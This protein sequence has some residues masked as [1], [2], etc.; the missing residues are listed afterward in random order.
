MVEK[1]YQA[2]AKHLSE[3]FDEGGVSPVTKLSPELTVSQA[4]QIQ[5][6]TIANELS[7]GNQITG[8]KIGLTSVAMQQSLGVDE[9]DYG[10][11]LASMEIVNGGKVSP[12]KVLQPKVE[13]ELA[14]VLK[15]ELRGP[16]V[17][18]LDVVMATDYVVPALEIV[19]SRIKNWEITLAD[20]VADN[21]SSGLY[22]LGEERFNLADCDLKNIG[23]ALYKNGELLN[24]GAG[25]ACLGNPL[26]GV[27]WLANK[28][29]EFEIPLKK[30]E[31]ILSGALSE[32]MP[33]KPG[34]VFT[35][36]F[37]RMGELTVRF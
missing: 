26:N 10:H 28:L 31:V 27:V 23:M 32:A 3:A 36:K 24:T 6:E 14:F 11:L 18:T 20:T 2:L 30:G 12:D 16:H 22:V 4:Y 7:K 25:V 35:C 9:P 29:A 17:T 1:K 19:D 8:K 33:A 21:A 5:L 15:K 37:N 34:D 13:G